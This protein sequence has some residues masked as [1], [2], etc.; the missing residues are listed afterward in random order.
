MITANWKDVFILF[1]VQWKVPVHLISHSELI[2]VFERQDFNLSFLKKDEF[3]KSV[4]LIKEIFLTL[5][6]L[7]MNN[8]ELELFKMLVLLRSG[9]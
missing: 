2:S 5:Y 4:E 6:Y 7:N 8:Q 1:L 9:K 3:L